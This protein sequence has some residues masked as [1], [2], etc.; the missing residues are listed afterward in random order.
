MGSS[1]SVLP[2]LL[3]LYPGRLV[4]QAY[5][6]VRVA[7]V[8][9]LFSSTSQELENSEFIVIFRFFGSNLFR[10]LVSPVHVFP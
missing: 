3:P 1:R 2:F 8:L 7:P 5:Y 6:P 9:H 4:I 10:P